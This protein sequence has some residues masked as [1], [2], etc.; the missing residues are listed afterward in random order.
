MIQVSTGGEKTRSIDQ[1]IDAYY[2]AGIRNIELSG[3]PYYAAGLE[4][5]HSH[6]KK[7]SDLKVS[8]HNYFPVP[9]TPFVFNLGSL[10]PDI[11]NKSFAHA[12]NAIDWAKKLGSSWYSFHAGFLIDPQVRE[13]GEK[14]SKRTLYDRNESMNKFISAV[15][16]LSAYGKGKGIRLYVENNVLS[17]KNH[18]EFQTNPLLCVTPEETISCME[19]LKGHAQLLVDVAHL[20]VSAR[21]LGFDAEDFITTCAPYTDA[22]HLSDND[23]SEDSNENFNQNSW[24]IPHLK[25][26]VSFVTIEVYRHS[27]EELKRLVDLVFE[28]N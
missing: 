15:K 6:L 21:S 12:K 17:E 3:G 14:I 19:Q 27:P 25:Q 26:G 10:N 24:F 16:E 8:V 5:L 11:F 28:K 18:R 7:Y 13:I 23:G 9:E 22:Y 20:K 4:G 2:A 1:T